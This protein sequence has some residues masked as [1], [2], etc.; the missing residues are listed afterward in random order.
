MIYTKYVIYFMKKP[1]LVLMAILTFLWTTAQ[2][3][4]AIN[5]QAIARDGGGNPLVSRNISLRLTIN[6]GINPGF[7][8]YQ[9]TQ[10]AT[11]NQ[12]GLFTVK[13]GYGNPVIGS[14]TAITWAGGN[15]YLLVE[16]D[17]NGGINYLNM[18]SSEL[19]SVPYALY[20][21]TAG[22]AAGT[23]ATGPTGPTGPQGVAGTAGNNGFTGPTGPTG[24]N[25]VGITGANGS[26]GATGPTGV[27]ITGP[28]GATGVTGL[29]LTGPTG[30]TGVT[31]A[32]GGAT[33][34]TGATGN[35][36]NDGATG[37]TG[38]GITGPTGATGTNGVTGITGP[39][40]L[41]G[42]GGGATG[43]TGATGNNGA[44]GATGATGVGIT[45][46][47]GATGN[48]G[49][50]GVTG[51]TG[52]TGAGG[53]ATGATGATGNNGSTGATGA[54]GVGVTGP[55]GTPGTNGVTG[56]TGPTGVTGAGGG[57]TGATGATGNN[58]NDGATGATG[59]GI[60]GPTGATGTNGVTGA[61]G[62]TG[63]TG[64][65]GGATGPTGATGNNGATGATGIGISGPTGATGN[66]GPTG[67]NGSNGT[68]GVTGPTGATGATGVGVTGPTGNNG[69]T[70]LT[71]VGITGPTG[72]TGNNGTTGTNGSN[73][74]TGATGPTG[75]T[76]ATGVG[77]TG[78]TGNNGATGLTGVGITGP[79]GATG[80][81]GPTGTNGTTG[82]T[83]IGITGATG[84][85]GVGVT[86]ATGADGALNAWGIT[87]NAGTNTATNFIG[88]IDNQDWVIKTNNIEAARVKTTGRLGLGTSVPVGTV[89][90]I[91]AT[92]GANEIF[93]SSNYGN[94]NEFWFRRAQGT[95]A[96][97]SLINNTG[98]LARII[99]KGYD[100]SAFQNA[101]EIEMAVDAGSGA[102]DMPGRISFYTTPDASTILAERMR[103]DNTGKVGIATVAPN[104]YLDINGDYAY[105]VSSSI[106]NTSANNNN[107]DLITNKFSSYRIT[108]TTGNDFTYSGFTGGT[109]GRIVTLY[110]ASNEN[111]DLLDQNATSLAANRII[112]GQ[113][114]DIT[115]GN[116][117]SVTMQYNTVDNRWVVIN[118]MGI[119]E[120][121]TSWGL[122]GN[123]GTTAPTSI[124]GAAINNN[125]IG[126]TDTKDFVIAANNKE[127]MRFYA[128]SY[129]IGIGQ[130]SPQYAIDL[131]VNPDAVFPCGRNGVRILQPGSSNACNNGLF[132][133][134]S[135][136]NADNAMLWN[137]SG[138][139]SNSY[140]SFGLGDPSLSYNEEIR[141]VP[142][143]VNINS[144]INTDA[145]LNIMDN[146]A[147]KLF[148]MMVS[149][150]GNAPGT[151]GTLY[152]LSNGGLHD[153]AV[154]WNYRPNSILFGTNDAQRV[155]ISGSGKVGINISS[156]TYL[157]DIYSNSAVS[158]VRVQGILPGYITD[159]LLTINSSGIIGRMKASDMFSVPSAWT[160]SGNSGTVDG[161]NFIGT[162]D[163]IPLNIRVNNQKAGRI[164]HLLYN[165]SFGFQSGNANT[166]G[167]YNT[168]NGYRALYLNTIGGYN[169]AS[170]ANALYSN[171]SGIFN[172]ANGVQALYSNTNGNYNTANG[173]NALYNNTTGNYNTATGED[174][175]YSNT[176]SQY[177]TATG[178]G[179]LYSNST[180]NNNT[181]SGW[182]ALYLNTSSDNTAT[183]SYALYSNTTGQGNTANGVNALTTNNTGNSNTANG[184]NA[185]YS[186][187]NGTRNTADG[188][189]SLYS[190]NTGYYNTASGY[191]A[192]YTNTSGFENTGTGYM[193][194][195]LNTTGNSN[196]AYGKNALYNNTS[197]NY[198]TGSGYQ[199]LFGN[200][201]G[202]YNTAMG[203][204]ALNVNSTGNYNTGLGYSAGVG[205]SA[206][207]NA[208][209]IG[210]YATVNASNC[211]VLGSVSGI[212]GATV[213]VNVGIGTN[214]PLYMLEVNGTVAKPGGG[215]WT[216]SSDARLKQEIKP[217]TDGLQQL[218]KISPV[219]YHYNQVSGFDTK[220]EYVGVIAQQLKKIAPYMIGSYTKE[221]T[222][223]YNVNNSAMTYMLINSVKE[224]KEIIDRQ[225]KEIEE[226][227]KK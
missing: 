142:H 129:L 104:N 132:L 59:V 5:Y 37:A 22:G 120:A 222:E 176:S 51:P 157:L 50:T 160:L 209:A 45:G 57:A 75:A 194:L 32:G 65:G 223:Y 226:L 12:F 53:G 36:G 117:A 182:K 4:Q 41:T 178:M 211:L 83:G 224:L 172:T 21:E 18:G 105:R 134:I 63:V 99:G 95:L 94:P 109:N 197:G 19:V 219:T 144:P 35:N 76:G 216:A 221:G 190:N 55:T 191:S 173:V 90:A 17:P 7:P 140:L 180:G 122:T 79:T 161:T 188:Y 54:T 87:G 227:K 213:T 115:I 110:N 71:G 174:A 155:E 13:I 186:N 86:G 169:T 159:S 85:T 66:N 60:T 177:N 28:T 204:S 147:T 23:G 93:V 39:T 40:G 167:N 145:V 138:T 139:N 14:F 82:A 15:K 2:V 118:S 143:A 61:T 102:G 1:I 187:T 125:F 58:G 220:P 165:T 88:T 67:T 166:S 123:S 101:A 6:T 119:Q 108:N 3:P 179:A 77:V 91:N 133:G 92:A 192:L 189:Q 154:I 68:T 121:V 25:G 136:D 137:M 158:P 98:I 130:A 72:A 195:Q 212:N 170:G 126:T 146:S 31:G 198:N 8:V 24:A 34:A 202:I 112:T 162:T 44:V 148:G 116:Q 135:S 26:P 106:V 96:A 185:L 208:T 62:P 97:P 30:P 27:G 193:A 205:T 217:Y 89:E 206:L 163:N 38:V 181:A 9:E 48:N 42:A 33:G 215:T 196:S 200:T 100:G 183:G 29:G 73:G 74:S 43:P 199:A 175:L 218:L 70:G 210:A 103:I 107:F 131:K 69:A 153:D 225:Q 128:N 114:G 141:I 150:G 164:D 124:V 168:A 81:T 149:Y 111:I 151:R 152:G 203:T 80:L 127:R 171:T 156:P 214:A 207:T 78:P 46:P 49:V 52:V 56:A 16:F 11:T 201:T 47:T 20:A 113:G 10:T 184:V 84:P 64:A